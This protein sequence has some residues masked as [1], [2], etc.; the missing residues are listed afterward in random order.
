MGNQCPEGYE[1]Q[2]GVCYKECESGYTM[3][4]EGMCVLNCPFGWQDVDNTCLKPPRSNYRNGTG[5][6][7]KLECAKIGGECYACNGLYYPVCYPGF[8]NVSCD[9]C[10]PICQDGTVTQDN[11][12]K[13]VSKKSSNVIPS[14]LSYT[15]IFI[16]LTLLLI[17]IAIFIRIF[18]KGSITGEDIFDIEYGTPGKNDAFSIITGE[19]SSTKKI[20]I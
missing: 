12:C 4:D 17:A 8:S 15:M 11:S 20:Y 9:I 14:Q 10:T 2:S 1:L 18:Q 13:K 16:I 7:T 6:A 3:N 19:K 5:F